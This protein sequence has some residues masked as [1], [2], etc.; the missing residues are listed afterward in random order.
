MKTIILTEQD[1]ILVYRLHIQNSRI[2]I[3]RVLVPL[4]WYLILIGILFLGISI[5]LGKHTSYEFISHAISYLG[6]LF[7]LLGF[8]V[9]LMPFIAKYTAKNTWRKN[10]ILHHSYILTWDQNNLSAHSDISEHK[11]K[12][13]AYC[14]TVQDENYILAY[15]QQNLFFIIPKRFFESSEEVHDF[16]NHLDSGI[17][18][19]KE[20][21]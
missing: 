2:L 17:K 12:W 4:R 18:K 5:C 13:S 9:F 7:F 10:K 21:T 11:H 8:I 19:N 16:L 3:Y 20:S 1:L 6:L 15:Y 14:Q